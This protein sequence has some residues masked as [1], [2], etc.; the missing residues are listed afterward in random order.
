MKLTQAQW[1]AQTERIR[2]GRE[3]VQTVP[4]SELDMLSDRRAVDIIALTNGIISIV[5]RMGINDGTMEVISV[6][7]QTAYAF[8]KRDAQPI[9]DAFTN[10][11]DAPA[12][13]QGGDVSEEE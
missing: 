9:P 13:T 6:A 10:A 8:G 3:L 1:D 2:A 11:L 4:Q 12:S 7:V 5:E